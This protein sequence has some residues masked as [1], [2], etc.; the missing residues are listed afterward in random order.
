M[1]KDRLRLELRDG[2]DC[3]SGPVEWEAALRPIGVRVG[4]A[5]IAAVSQVFQS[6]QRYSS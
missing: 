1:G 5:I 2:I 3:L 6:H 4:P